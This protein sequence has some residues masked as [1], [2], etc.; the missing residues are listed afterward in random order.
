[1]HG[2]STTEITPNASVS[3]RAFLAGAASLPVASLPIV[4]IAANKSDLV[5]M[6][7]RHRALSKRIA[8][9]DDEC[10]ILMS[11]ADRPTLPQVQLGEFTDRFKGT[12]EETRVFDSPMAIEKFRQRNALG[13]RTDVDAEA[14]RLH[15]LYEVR[16]AALDRWYAEV[17]FDDVE[18]EMDERGDEARTLSRWIAACPCRSMADVALKLDFL[19]EFYSPTENDWEPL[20]VLLKS[21]RDFAA[22]E[23]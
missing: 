15:D 14:Q 8:E 16:R 17:G 18:R 2:P 19:E 9:L 12:S 4:A 13:W 1:M 5:M 7:D 11:R 21:I 20:T 23:A 10:G 22:G 6:I 3:R